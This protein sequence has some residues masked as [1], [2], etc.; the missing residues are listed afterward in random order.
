MKKIIILILLLFIISCKKNEFIN[1]TFSYSSLDENGNKT[2]LDL[3]IDSLGLVTGSKGY[4]S[5]ER[6]SGYRDIS[7]KLEGEEIVGNAY[8][9]NKDENMELKIKLHKD[10]AEYYEQNKE[11]IKL[12]LNESFHNESSSSLASDDEVSDAEKMKEILFAKKI[13]FQQIFTEKDEFGNQSFAV[14][15]DTPYEG[16]FNKDGKFQELS[17][18]T[19]EII[20]Q[21]FEFK[22]YALVLHRKIFGIRES[23][24]SPPKDD[25]IYNFEMYLRNYG[26][27]LI[28]K[29]VQP[30]K[31]GKYCGMLIYNTTDYEIYN[32][33]RD[34]IKNDF[35]QLNNEK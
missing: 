31:F 8:T 5:D 28:D 26:I 6:I 18:N 22:P 14:Y 34:E 11:L 25:R 24:N 29:S 13:K 10:Y 4:I 20:S 21:N 1:H 16:K 23:R 3:K 32:T 17:Y 35:K 9:M 33:Y 2:F 15:L 27:L 30:T 7:G 12:S 19:N